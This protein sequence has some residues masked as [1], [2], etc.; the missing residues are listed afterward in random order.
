LT[1]VKPRLWEHAFVTYADALLLLFELADREDARFRSAAARWHA[2]FVLAAGLDLSEADMVM[3]ML[4]G[5][6]G[7]NR[8]VLRRRLLERVQ[9]AGLTA[10]EIPAEH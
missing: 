8:Q 2:R 7:P 3:K 1:H 6:R 4:S 10:A 9:F 5:V